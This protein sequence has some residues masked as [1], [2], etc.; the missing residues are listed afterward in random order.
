MA[1][2]GY[3]SH[4]QFPA[5]LCVRHTIAG[6]NVG[7]AYGN[8]RDAIPFL[9]STML[10]EGPCIHQP[11]SLGEF[12]AHGHYTNLVNPQYTRLGI[13]IYSKN[14]ITWLTEDFVR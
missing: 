1:Q 9:H 13:G 6:E 8:P 10:K 2:L 11:C 3:I 5:D 14:G 12:A 4:D 7:A